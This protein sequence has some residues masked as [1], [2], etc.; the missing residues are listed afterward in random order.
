MNK[1]TIMAEPE[2]TVK[3]IAILTKICIGSEKFPVDAERFHK[4]L[5]NF[6]L[7]LLPFREWWNKTTL[8]LDMAI[9]TDFLEKRMTVNAFLAVVRFEQILNMGVV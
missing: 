5:L 7:K 9:G 2:Q 1:I 4:E 3:I 8:T 6:G